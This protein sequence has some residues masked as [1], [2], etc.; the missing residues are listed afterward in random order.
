MLSAFAQ[1]FSAHSIH[2][3]GETEVQAQGEEPGSTSPPPQQGEGSPT[4]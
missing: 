3:R 2:L 4:A 1:Q